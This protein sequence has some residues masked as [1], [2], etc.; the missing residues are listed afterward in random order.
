MR[1]KFYHAKLP[2]LDMRDGIAIQMK[3][4]WARRD[5]T[6]PIHEQMLTGGINSKVP[7][8]D[9][10]PLFIDYDRMYIKRVKREV[11][12]LMEKHKLGDAY[13]FSSVPDSFHVKFFYDWFPFNKMLKIVKSIE[14]EPGYPMIVK[15]Q[16]YTT[17]RTCSKWDKR[18]PVYK[19]RI[20]SP[21]QKYKTKRELDWGDMLRM[22]VL[23][24]LDVKHFKMMD[25]RK[26]E[27][28]G[29]TGK[30]YE[31]AKKTDWNPWIKELKGIIEKETFEKYPDDLLEK[32]QKYLR[33]KI[34]EKR[35]RKKRLPLPPLIS[36]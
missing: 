6:R 29:F 28:L 11:K 27:V 8:T 31:E 1:T 32:C 18:I 14:E 26:G 9:L 22:A 34:R 7:G 19:G 13:L 12:E 5:P 21:Y 17:L 10:H 30:M 15:K 20:A 4:Y 33:E 23:T 35:K 25:F 2:P 36:S 24:L 16:G 3:F